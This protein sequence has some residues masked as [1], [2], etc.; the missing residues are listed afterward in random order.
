MDPEA[1]LW[2]CHKTGCGQPW[3]AGLSRWGLALQ[4]ERSLV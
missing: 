2:S 3:P 4:S 1:A